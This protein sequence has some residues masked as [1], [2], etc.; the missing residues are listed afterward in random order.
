MY[1]DGL[2]KYVSAGTQPN[3]QGT[4]L[5]GIGWNNPPAAWKDGRCVGDLES[6]VDGSEIDGYTRIH[7]VVSLPTG[8]F[9]VSW[10]PLVEFFAKDTPGSVPFQERLPKAIGLLE[11][12]DLL[13]S[14]KGQNSR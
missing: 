6:L 10:F 13:R 12:G 1:S 11:H 4:V 8:R 3:A 2:V 9:G 14:G 5:C 7:A